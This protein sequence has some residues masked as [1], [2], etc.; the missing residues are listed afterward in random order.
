MK[1]GPGASS[2]IFSNI[3]NFDEILVPKE[4][5]INGIGDIRCI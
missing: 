3:F 2:N 4:V 1:V 5:E